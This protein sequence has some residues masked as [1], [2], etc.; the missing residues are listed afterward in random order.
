MACFCEQCL[1]SENGKKGEKED[2]MHKK[3]QIPS[4]FLRHFALVYIVGIYYLQN[5]LG[6]LPVLFYGSLHKCIFV[7]EREYYDFKPDSS[8]YD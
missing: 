7:K 1:I 2:A 6:I 4:S 8:K 3:K 5:K